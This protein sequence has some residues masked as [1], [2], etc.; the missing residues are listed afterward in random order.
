MKKMVINRALS[1]TKTN[2]IKIKLHLSERKGTVTTTS[3]AKTLMRNL[4]KR[5]LHTSSTVC[6]RSKAKKENKKEKYSELCR[7]QCS[8]QQHS[9][10]S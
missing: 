8:K 2:Q 6:F 10:L 4:L 1:P 3:K 5:K 9:R 7:Q